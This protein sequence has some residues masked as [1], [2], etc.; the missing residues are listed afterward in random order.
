M[1][2]KNLEAIHKHDLN[3][4]LKNLEL[5]NKFNEKSIKCK[6]CN[7]V[8]EVNNFGAIFTKDKKINFSCSKLNCLSNLNK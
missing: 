4:L 8:I 7:D 1:D 2:E 3:E 5:L 6:F